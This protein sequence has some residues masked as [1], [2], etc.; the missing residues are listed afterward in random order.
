MVGHVTKDG[1][2]DMMST[3]E[4]AHKYGISTCHT[5]GKVEKISNYEYCDSVGKEEWIVTHA[6]S[7]DGDSG[8]VHYKVHDSLGAI[9]VIGVHHASNY[10]DNPVVGSA[11]RLNNKYGIEFGPVE[12]ASPPPKL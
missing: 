7:Q 8:G 11:Y 12:P 3:G 10:V 4:L 5:S 6:E 9:T 1:V 2:D